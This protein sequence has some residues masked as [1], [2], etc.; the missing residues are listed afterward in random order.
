MCAVSNVGDYYSQKW[1]HHQYPTGS[2]MGQQGGTMPLYAVSREE[3]ETLKK[4]VLE[5]KDLLIKAKE[6]DTKTR[7]KDCE[8]EQKLKVLRAVADAV[9]IS[10]DDVLPKTAKLAINP[11]KQV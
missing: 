9:G 4:E 5:M 11:G 1:Q 10:L 3:F 8:M 7:Q 6:I 2:G